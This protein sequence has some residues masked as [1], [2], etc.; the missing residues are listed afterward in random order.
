M[1]RLPLIALA[2][3]VSCARTTPFGALNISANDDQQAQY[4]L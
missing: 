3:L 1:K 4:S 2:L